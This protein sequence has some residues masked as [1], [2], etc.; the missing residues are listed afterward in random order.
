MQS[1]KRILAIDGPFS[2]EVLGPH[3]KRFT[4]HNLSQVFSDSLQLDDQSLSM[5]NRIKLHYQ[6]DNVADSYHNIAQEKLAN[7]GNKNYVKGVFEN[8]HHYL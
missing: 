8:E 5:K 7:Y 6:W 2:E 1:T 4:I 3:G